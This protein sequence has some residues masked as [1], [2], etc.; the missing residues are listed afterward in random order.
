M[1]TKKILKNYSNKTKIKTDEH[2]Q[3]KNSRRIREILD[4]CDKF[5]A[6]VFDIV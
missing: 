5:Y 6:H 1:T 3:S 4:F 2:N